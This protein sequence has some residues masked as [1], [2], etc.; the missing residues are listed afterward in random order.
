MLYDHLLTV[1]QEVNHIWQRRFSGATVIFILNRYLTLTAV[2]FAMAS[3]ICTGCYCV[4]FA[5]TVTNVMF[6]LVL[7][8]QAGM[9]NSCISIQMTEISK[10]LP[11]WESTPFGATVFGWLY[12]S[13]SSILYPLYS[14]AWALSLL[15]CWITVLTLD[16]LTMFIGGHYSFVAHIGCMKLMGYFGTIQRVQSIV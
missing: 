9:N 8:T 12:Q 5:N 13:C 7:L 3:S 10:Y 6:I 2:V 14:E 1:R 15:S 4:Q 11:A 16:Q